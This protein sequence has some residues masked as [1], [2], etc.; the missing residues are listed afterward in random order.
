MGLSAPPRPRIRR[1]RQPELFINRELSWLEF[2]GRVLEE[3][4]DPSVP[5]LERLKFAIITSTNM[6]EFFMVRVAALKRRIRE[7]DQIPAPDGLTPAATM[8]AVSARVHQLVELQHRT[9]LQDLQPPLAAEGVLLLRPKE[10][11]DEQRRFLED[12]FRRTLLPV[13]TPLAVDPGHPFPYLGNRSLCLI[14]SMRPTA[15]SVFPHSRLS[16]IHIPSQALPRFIALPEGQGKRAFMLL[17]DVVRLHLPSI[18]HGYEIL[19][20]HAIRVTR[21]A[22]LPEPPTRTTDLLSGIERSL[23][24][25]RLGDAVRLQHDGDLPP[26]ILTLLLEELELHADDV[27]EGAGFAAFSD[28]LQ[29]YTAL[30]IARL[31]DPPRPPHAVAELEGTTDVWG[32]IRARDVLVHHPYQSFDS[33]IR[34]VR[35]AATDPRVLAIKM[36]LYRVSP[37][38]PI[39]HAL[40][41]AVE[42][43]K[44]VAVLV[45]LQARFDEE[46]NIRWARA[47]EEV[48]AHV[49]YG[50]PGFKT[51]CKACLVVRQEPDGIR[52]YCHL[53]TGNYNVRTAG[54]YTDIGFFTSRQSF[55]EDLT[56]LFNLLTGYSRQDRFRTLL[57]APMTLRRRLVELIDREVALQ[58]RGEQGHV[59]IKINGLTD[60]RMIDTLYR[61]SQA[62]VKIDVIV[63]GMCSL[64]PGA[65]GLSENIRVVSIVGRFLEHSRLYYFRNGGDDELYAGSADLMP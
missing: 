8:A 35:E 50:F 15:P 63:R 17:E 56:Q 29:L 19:S 9:F 45:E 60:A 6:D 11:T 36:T 2:N 44:E 37:A 13:V 38:S 64:R 55:G 59:M 51:H 22:D 41:T 42:N 30:D 31:K 4:T 43:G 16:I 12:Y 28:L 46:A 32:A 24:E 18:Y 58:A 5:L 54:V 20:S 48:G 1:K 40:Q 49:V 61:A 10:I 23:R 25:R 53:A 14:A 52:R 3:A 62:G 39:A 34:F 65:P 33:V 27:Y 26:E 47:L 7:G 57:V 21:D